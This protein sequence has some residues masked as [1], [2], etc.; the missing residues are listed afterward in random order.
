MVQVPARFS[1]A[2]G[3][4]PRMPC[5]EPLYDIYYYLSTAPRHYFQPAPAVT[6]INAERQQMAYFD[7]F[8]SR[9]H[10]SA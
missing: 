3:E 10:A 6:A 1:A 7:T 8:R 9:C 2:E 5:V 4:Q